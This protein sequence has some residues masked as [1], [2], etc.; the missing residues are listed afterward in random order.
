MRRSIISLAVAASWVFSSA[1]AYEPEGGIWW[2]PQESG[3]G[4]AIETQDDMMAVTI[5]GGDAAG[6]A[7]WYTSVGRLDYRNGAVRFQAEQADFAPRT[8]FPA[9]PPGR[10]DIYTH[11]THHAQSTQPHPTSQQSRPDE[12]PPALQPW[13]MD[14]PRHHTTATHRPA[15]CRTASKH[16]TP[17]TA[18]R[19]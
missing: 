2:N 19:K 15:S 9:D 13:P 3:T 4:Y 5:Y 18:Q 11:R 12:P 8:T 7:K 16:P 10:H 14:Q 1:H 17:A 6:F